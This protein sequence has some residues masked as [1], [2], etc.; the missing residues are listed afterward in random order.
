METFEA[1]QNGRIKM[2]KR[3]LVIDDDSDIRDYFRILL[4]SYNYKV[5]EAENTTVGEKLLREAET[6]LIVLDVM[7]ERD[8]EGFNFAQKIKQKDQ[9]KGIPI[10]MVTSVNQKTPFNFDKERDGAFIPVDEFIEK[11]VET[12]KFITAVEKYLN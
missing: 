6:D 12:H 7:M 8:S 3:I 4:E 10:I 5:S 1:H 11:P 2:A 9:Y